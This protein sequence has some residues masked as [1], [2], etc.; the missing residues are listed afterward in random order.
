M[1]KVIDDTGT[2]CDQFAATAAATAAAHASEPAV[3][4]ADGAL[5]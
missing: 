3:R 4:T 5:V 1:T 2:L